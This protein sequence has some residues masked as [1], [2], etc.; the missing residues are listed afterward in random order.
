MHDE[1][2]QAEDA[3]GPRILALYELLKRISDNPMVLLNHAIAAAAVQGPLKGLELLDASTPMRASLAII[4]SMPFAPICSAWLA[5]HK[6]RQ[7]T[8]A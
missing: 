6:P 7:R 1:A 3:D 2:S 8:T 4:A 5:T